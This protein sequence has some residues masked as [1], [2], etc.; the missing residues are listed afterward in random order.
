MSDV[1]EINLDMLDRA[2][3]EASQGGT[4]NIMSTIHNL[5]VYNP[6]LN[7]PIEEDK[8]NKFKIV[9]ANKSEELFI[10]GELVFNPLDV[11]YA[12]SGA[13]FPL[14]ENGTYADTKVFF[15]TSEF[16]K[17]AK[18]TDVI[19]F[20]ANN[21]GFG[22]FE[23]AQLENMLKTPGLNGKENHFYEKKK[24]AEG[25]PYA[26]SVI[27]KTAVIYGTFTGGKYDG[28]VFRMFVNPK[29]LGVTF[30][31]GEVCDPD[32]GT[33][34]YACNQGLSEMNA[35]L[36]ANGRKPVRSI[37]PTQ[38]DVTLTIH[39]NDKK[40]FLPVFTY[41]GLVAKRGVDNTEM[42]E[43]V[44]GLKAEH[45]AGIFG[46]VGPATPIMINNGSAN[47]ELQPLQLKAKTDDTIQKVDQAQQVF[48]TVDTNQDIPAF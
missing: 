27:S 8:A 39:Q 17:F 14:L 13:V 48:E 21:K 11:A 10:E 3:E 9:E 12:Y 31:D 46:S 42:I 1:T 19:G 26:G 6:K 40:N 36:E 32:E 16:G 25:V 43:F 37:S 33:F 4:G 7:T 28:E 23:K 44:R 2:E 22:F 35:L 45:F 24:N 38:V 30:R 15:S 5:K 34:E 18:K 20:S 29:H 41:K 47:V